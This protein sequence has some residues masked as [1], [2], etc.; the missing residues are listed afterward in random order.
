MKTA[1]RQL[2]LGQIDQVMVMV[3]DPKL[4]AN[5]LALLANLRELF[6]E[7]ADISQLAVSQ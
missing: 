2:A 4:R 5:R 1:R 6:W 7:V 3:E